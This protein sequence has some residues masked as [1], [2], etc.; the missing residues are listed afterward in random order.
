M[1]AELVKKLSLTQGNSK[2]T[3]ELFP[4]FDTQLP[5][6]SDKKVCVWVRD[7]WSIDENSVRVDAGQAGNQ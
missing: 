5:S 2:V 7:G 4:V 3:R 6:D 1:F